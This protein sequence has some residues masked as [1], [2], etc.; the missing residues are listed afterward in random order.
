MVLVV[1]WEVSELACPSS[2]VTIVLTIDEISLECCLHVVAG[3]CPL[4]QGV[5]GI[6]MSLLALSSMSSSN[7]MDLWVALFVGR[8]TSRRYCATHEFAV[9]SS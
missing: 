4:Y 2:R 6:E 8:T 1:V 7:L 3:R 9:Q 5:N